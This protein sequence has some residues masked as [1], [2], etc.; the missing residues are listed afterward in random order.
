MKNLRV[1]I[2]LFC[3]VITG[4]CA[5]AFNTSRAAA[6]TVTPIDNAN[7]GSIDNARTFL[8]NNNS[9]Y[10]VYVNGQNVLYKINAGDDW[11][12]STNAATT[13]TK[14]SGGNIKQECFSIAQ[15]GYVFKSNFQSNIHPNP[16]TGQNC[17]LNNQ[18]SSNYM[19]GE[20]NIDPPD[21][22][23]MAI[24]ITDIDGTVANRQLIQFTNKS[25]VQY[26]Y[27]PN[28][29]ISYSYGEGAY[30]GTFRNTGS[31]GES[32]GQCTS[33]ITRCSA[34]ILLLGNSYKVTVSMKSP[35][36]GMDINNNIYQQYRTLTF[37]PNEGTIP[38]S[39]KGKDHTVRLWEHPSG[40][41]NKNLSREYKK[42]AYVGYYP[43][44]QRSGWT[45]NGWYT[46]C[47]G[48]TN[49]R[50]GGDEDG[51]RFNISGNTTL[52]AQWTP[53][54]TWQITPTTTV[55]VNNGHSVTEAKPGDTI[56]W[57]HTITANN[58]DPPATTAFGYQSTGPT[59]F[60]GSNLNAFTNQNLAASGSNTQ[61]STYTIPTDATNGTQYCRNSV[62]TDSSY[63]SGAQTA[64]SGNSCV[65]VSTS[66]DINGS[67]TIRNSSGTNLVSA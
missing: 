48:G 12:I 32:N 18:T 24:W 4:F 35:K 19:V 43:I 51:Y 5:V 20:I 60:S 62:V 42:D 63:L 33:I 46:A 56:T 10:L 49:Y 11:N 2:T 40:P 1:A 8:Q 14:N 58:D 27:T 39:Q 25:T 9:G 29:S 26:V 53:D 45:F 52:C 30:S 54:P 66:F 23:P 36:G 65:T 57:K 59:G 37:N 31:G 34:I 28:A 55:S 3:A 13:V 47:S 41:D 15:S 38:D 7:L 16:N 61:E 50:T 67:I 64:T 21:N 44:P 22:L 17:G 6:S